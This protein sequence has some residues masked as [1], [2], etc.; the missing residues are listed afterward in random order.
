M[1]GTIYTRTVYETRQKICHSCF[2][3][4]LHC[5]CKAPPIQGLKQK[6]IKQKNLLKSDQMQNK[7]SYND[8]M[9][10]RF[11]ALLFKLL[12]ISYR[13]GKDFDIQVGMR[14]EVQ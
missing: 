14:S 6:T 1:V 2:G 12:S 11:I 13:K 9:V 10:Q 3:Q 7:A 5:I 4:L 8:C